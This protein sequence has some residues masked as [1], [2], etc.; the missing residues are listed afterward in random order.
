MTRPSR[1]KTK[2]LPTTP[3]TPQQKT[4]AAPSVQIE[5]QEL[6]NAL[7]SGLQHIEVLFTHEEPPE[8]GVEAAKGLLE[9]VKRMHEILEHEYAEAY[10][11]HTLSDY[12]DAVREEQ[13]HDSPEGRRLLHDA[14]EQMQRGDKWRHAVHDQVLKV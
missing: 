14:R 11:Q 13:M 5:K 12:R 7:D 8:A 10:I 4:T 1:L 6:L 2:L 9:V 3:R